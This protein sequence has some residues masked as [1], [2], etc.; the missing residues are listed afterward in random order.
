MLS[1]VPDCPVLNTGEWDEKGIR[2]E[3]TQTG[4]SKP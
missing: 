3:P 2:D 4:S 1:E